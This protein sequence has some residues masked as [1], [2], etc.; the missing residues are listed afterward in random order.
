[1]GIV[2]FISNVKKT[3]EQINSS[4]LILEEVKSICMKKY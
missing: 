2:V 1:M 3:K 4:K